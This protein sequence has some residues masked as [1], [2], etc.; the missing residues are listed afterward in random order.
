MK[1][2]ITAA[3]GG[4]LG[5]AG[6]F[7]AA[8]L[9]TATPASADVGCSPDFVC[10]VLDQPGVFAED[11]ASQPGVFLES[12]DPFVLTNRFVAGACGDYQGGP[13]TDNETSCG[14]TQ[15][16]DHFWENSEGTGVSQQ[17]E[18]F[19]TDLASQPGTF[20]AND[21]GTGITQ[22]G[23]TFVDS[24]TKPFGPDSGPDHDD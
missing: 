2:I 22:Q 11:L 24:I 3:A 14:I 17:L 6:A 18:T 12:V 1:R 4:V 9:I 20:L 19:A 10:D 5:A 21:D 16:L 13:V 15:Q 8:A 23:Q 7:G